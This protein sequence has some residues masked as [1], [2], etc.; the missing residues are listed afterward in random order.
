MEKQE[1]IIRSAR[2][3]DLPAIQLI[4]TSARKYMRANG[5]HK[6]W[7]HG[8]PDDELLLS[9]IGKNQLF[10]IE[11]A[12]DGIICAAF[13]FIIGDDPTYSYIE[14]GSW[15][16]DTAYGTIHRIASD[17]T[18]RD[19]LRQ[20]VRF[21][22]EQIRHLRIDTHQDNHIMQQ[23]ILRNGFERR[24]IIYLEDGS[25]RIAYEKVG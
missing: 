15:L 6:Q 7:I 18:E 2:R 22:E 23:V 14:G 21:C 3:E 17:G 19:I 10:V 8:Y 16:S 9:D 20:A 12:V 5:N 25:P 24:G 13:A 1:R 11:K 4:Y